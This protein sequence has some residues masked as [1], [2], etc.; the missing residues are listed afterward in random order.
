M[1]VIIVQQPRST[2]KTH[3]FT[4]VTRDGRNVSMSVVTAVDINKNAV[5]ADLRE[6]MPGVS[7]LDFKKDDDFGFFSMAGMLL[8]LWFVLLVA[9]GIVCAVLEAADFFDFYAR[10][11]GYI[12]VA[13]GE[14]IMKGLFRLWVAAVPL[15]VIVLPAFLSW[16]ERY[17]KKTLKVGR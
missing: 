3:D 11:P 5:L 15:V 16:S 9:G 1:T 4:G 10:W 13:G 7:D 14:R 12:P 8:F 6:S 17:E 2:T